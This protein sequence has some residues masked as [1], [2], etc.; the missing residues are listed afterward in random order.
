MKQYL[1]FTY[2][3]FS[4]AHPYFYAHIRNSPIK[5]KLY[6]CKNRYKYKEGNNR[7]PSVDQITLVHTHDKS[8]NKCYTQDNTNTRETQVCE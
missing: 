8:G 3:S 1:N 5:Y 7:P 6:A 2:V 4:T